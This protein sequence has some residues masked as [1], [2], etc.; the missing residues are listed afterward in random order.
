MEEYFLKGFFYMDLLN[1]TFVTILGYKLSFLEFLATIAGIFNVYLLAK[2]KI[3]NYFWGIL[4]VILSFFIYYNV[5]MYSTMFLQV[6]YLVLNIYG[7]W[8]WSRSSDTDHQLKV[9]TNSKQY[10]I[11]A[12]IISFLGF[13]VLGFFLKNIHTILPQIF[14]Q[15]ESSPFFDSFI[16]TLSIVAMYFSAKKKLENWYLWFVA[17]FVSLIIFFDKDVKFISFQ[18]LVFLFFAFIG[19]IAW[20]KEIKEDFEASTC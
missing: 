14:K 4:N 6:Y 9:S 13:I 20:K 15:P 19:F 1:N 10:N 17:D 2:L 18:Y 5:Q 8:M 12:F 7:L 16:T 11:K 3:S